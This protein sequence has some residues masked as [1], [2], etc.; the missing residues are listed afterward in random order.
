M[1]FDSEEAQPKKK[2]KGKKEEKGKG[3]AGPSNNHEANTSDMV[4]SR[5]LYLP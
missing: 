1:I 3:K 4:S 5:Y 2:E